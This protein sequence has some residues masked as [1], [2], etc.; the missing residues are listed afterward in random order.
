MSGSTSGSPSLHPQWQE[1][2][3][4][5]K[6]KTAPKECRVEV[7]EPWPFISPILHHGLEKPPNNSIGRKLLA[8][9]RPLRKLAPDVEVRV[10]PD[11]DGERPTKKPIKGR[12]RASESRLVGAGS[13]T[14]IG[15]LPFWVRSFAK[16]ADGLYRRLRDYVHLS[17]PGM[18]SQQAPPNSIEE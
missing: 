16:R 12:P 11:G 1:P 2:G 14:V 13:D 17:Q 10:D 7:V 6:L 15:P 18:P 3:P 9:E 8:L 5:K 4:M